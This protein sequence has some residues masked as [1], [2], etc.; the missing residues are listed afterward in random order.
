MQR[1]REIHAAYQR[2]LRE[3]GVVV[4]WTQLVWPATHLA[5]SVTALVVLPA[6]LYAV[7]TD[8]MA[9]LSRGEERGRPARRG[10]GHGGTE[11]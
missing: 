1:L 5:A 6:V 8:L 4:W 11:R 3:V 7:G 10:G 9:R 2:R